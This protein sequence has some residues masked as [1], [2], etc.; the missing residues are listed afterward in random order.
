MS[1]IL[2]AYAL[3]LHHDNV[4]AYSV[5]LGF[6]GTKIADHHQISLEQLATWRLVRPADVGSLPI[7]W[8][9]LRGPHDAEAADA[10]NGHVV[11]PLFDVVPLWSNDDMIKYAL[12]ALLQPV[13]LRTTYTVSADFVTQ[14]EDRKA[15][16]L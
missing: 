16:F 14:A 12:R 7:V 8:A 1:N 2:H 3:P 15:E 10:Q 6:V 13:I 5:V 11:T 9:A 4:T